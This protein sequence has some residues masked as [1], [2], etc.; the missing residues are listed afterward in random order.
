MIVAEVEEDDRLGRH[1]TGRQDSAS[2]TKASEIKTADDVRN[3]LVQYR[4]G[5]VSL[6]RFLDGTEAA[7]K[8]DRSFRRCYRSSKTPICSG[9]DGLDVV[10][11]HEMMQISLKSTAVA[12]F[13]SPMEKFL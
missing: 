10:K 12:A 8:D 4:T 7:E 1:G 5:D 2:S 13:Q 11:V 3:V 6:P 9:Q